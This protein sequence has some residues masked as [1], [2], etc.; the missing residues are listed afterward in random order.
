MDKAREKHP[1]AYRPWTIEEDMKFETL[2]LEGKSIDEL[3][4]IFQRQRGGIRS[5]L[6]KMG[7]QRVKKK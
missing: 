1:N 2:A 4:L 5:R 7:L 3:M 6:N